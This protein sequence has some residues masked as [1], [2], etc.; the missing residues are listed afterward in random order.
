MFF[1]LADD[2][3]ERFHKRFE[4]WMDW[5]KLFQHAYSSGLGDLLPITEPKAGV[6]R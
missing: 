1:S 4:N 3:D 5:M 2:S 6:I